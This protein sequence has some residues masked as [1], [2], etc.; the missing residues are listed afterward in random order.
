MTSMREGHGSSYARS[1]HRDTALRSVG[2]KCSLLLG[3]RA[4]LPRYPPS[5]P[6]SSRPSSP[7]HR[8]SAACRSTPVWHGTMPCRV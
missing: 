6:S 8:D 5:P 1:M 3:S 2:T 4:P 7:R